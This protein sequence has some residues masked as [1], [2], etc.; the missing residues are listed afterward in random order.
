MYESEVID[1]NA[2]FP[3]KTNKSELTKLI[4]LNQFIS[5][6]DILISIK[7]STFFNQQN[8]LFFFIKIFRV[9]NETFFVNNMF[10][11]RLI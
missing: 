9:F 7:T 3:K 6:A 1:K 5:R 2:H 8:V 4:I 11:I 10:R